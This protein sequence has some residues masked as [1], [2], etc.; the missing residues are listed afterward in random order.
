M[1]L[2]LIP[3]HSS[4]PYSTPENRY[5][6]RFRPFANISIPELPPFAT[7][8]ACSSPLSARFP[9]SNYPKPRKKRSHDYRQALALLDCA[10]LA[11]QSA[12]QG[13]TALGKVDAETARCVGC[14]ERWRAKV[15]DVLRSVVAAGLAIA[16]LRE[17]VDAAVEADGKGKGRAERGLGLKVDV[18]VKKG[19]HE[20]WAVP[21]LGTVAKDAETR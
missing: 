13:W 20:W 15:K 4:P 5:R 2:S 11:N 8:A 9:L 18:D 1:A 10:K 12:R 17:A 3:T 19:Y 14:E 21:K 7:F 6:L 16:K